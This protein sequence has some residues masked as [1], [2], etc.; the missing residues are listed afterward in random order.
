M[1]FLD[2]YSG[3]QQT[4]L[5]PRPEETGDVPATFADTFKANWDEARLFSQSMAHNTARNEALL[6]YLD[7]VQ[8]KSGADLISGLGSSRED[9]IPG[10][11]A[12]VAKLKEQQP[13]LDVQPLTEEGLEQAAITKS[14]GAQQ[15]Y[16]AMAGRERTWGGTF[17][18]WAGNIAGAATDPLNIVAAPAAPAEGLGIL[19]TALR[20]GAI[21]AASQAAIEGVGGQYHEM[22]QP[23]YFASDEPL[24]NVLEGGAG[25]AILGGGSKALGTLWSRVKSGAWPTTVR[26]AGNVVESEANIA[27]TNVLPGVAGEVAHREA[28]ATAIDQI[29][30]G[31]SVDIEIQ[32]AGRALSARLER[33]APFTLPVINEHAIR[34]LSEEAGLRARSAEL[35]THLEGLP[36][37]DAKAAADTLARLDEIDRQAAEA[38]PQARRV[39]GQRRDEL[40]ADTSP[41]QLREQAGPLEQRRIAQAE[42]ASIAARLGDI[43][44]ERAQLKA[45]E[46][47]PVNMGQ[48][49][50]IPPMLYDIHQN[51]IDGLM[52]MRSAALDFAEQA[53]AEQAASPGRFSVVTDA[54]EQ[55]IIAQE[56]A[57]AGGETTQADLKAEIHRN[58]LAD[59][60][61]TLAQI[62]G[63]NMPRAEADTI[64][65]RVIRSTSDDEARAILQAVSDRPHTLAATLPTVEDVAR[66]RRADAA[67]APRPALQTS[68]QMQKA[69]GSPDHETAVRSDID[70]TRMNGD[71]QIPIGKDEN[72]EPIFRSL[73]SAM[74]EVDDY[75]AIAEQIQAC[76]A[77]Q[78]E[79]KAA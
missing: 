47:P 17:G 48:R 54:G 9:P 53:K 25:A 73:D 51:R 1:T 15:A 60:V 34:L 37:G 11:N 62:G 78:P 33:E 79:P 58:A 3:D 71:V 41:E 12:A 66:Q 7:D 5:R 38:T 69:L 10:V 18:S 23:G 31:Q 19:A 32:I 63:H 52:D 16:A 65:Q 29:L 45:A 20:W 56:R 72:G 67:A 28:L 14:Q 49:Q 42:Q 13:D 2:L 46:A 40:L 22:V 21:G 55:K 8:K 57:R 43:A 70:R 26:D 39:L 77:P 74:K 59:G 75:R 64:A 61:S 35:D 50:S 4:A 6:D 68:E 36:I 30:K 44:S 27:T 76:A 24:I